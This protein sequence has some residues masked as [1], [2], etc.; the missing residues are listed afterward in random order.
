MR[1]IEAENPTS[2]SSA[3]ETRTSMPETI[4]EEHTVA[5]VT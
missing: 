1:R 3:G 5:A 2:L 4:S